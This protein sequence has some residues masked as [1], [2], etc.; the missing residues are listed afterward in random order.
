MSKDNKKIDSL[1]KKWR[2]GRGGKMQI[3]RFT[4]GSI[5]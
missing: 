5:V 1:R 2:R 3:Y 4:L